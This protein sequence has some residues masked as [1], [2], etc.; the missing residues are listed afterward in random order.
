[1]PA[2]LRSSPLPLA[3]AL[4]LAL[5][6]AAVRAAPASFHVS[7]TVSSASFPDYHVLPGV[8]PGDAISGT[9]T[10][11]AAGD[12]QQSSP[13]AFEFNVGQLRVRSGPAGI[14]ITSG[15]I[16]G[17]AGSSFTLQNG[18]VG[19]SI[20]SDTRLFDVATLMQL[21]NGAGTLTLSGL[22]GR[23][24][25]SDAFRI[26]GNLAVALAP[27]PGALPLFLPGLAVLGLLR[28][29]T[30]RQDAKKGRKRDF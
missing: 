27:E 13:S 6:A 19:S 18:S 20:C 16:T 12:I 10:Y 30:N 15:L 26:N 23:G 5:P 2:W 1:L 24:Q 4:G 21:Q 25:P 22:T 9:F 17:P 11:D 3:F 14:R 28:R 29:G 8:A 7:G